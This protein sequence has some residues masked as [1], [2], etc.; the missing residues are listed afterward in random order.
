MPRRSVRVALG[1]SQQRRSATVLLVHVARLFNNVA[2]THQQLLPAREFHVRQQIT[3]HCAYRTLCSKSCA[4][5]GTVH[6]NI[7]TVP[8]DDVCITV[9]ETHETGGNV[10][11]N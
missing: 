9:V 6:A 10:H 8:C 11:P 2:F 3:H 4:L 7:R 5:A 1:R